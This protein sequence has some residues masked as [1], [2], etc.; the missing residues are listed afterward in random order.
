[1]PYTCGHCFPTKTFLILNAGVV[2]LAETNTSSLV[3]GTS[4]WGRCSGYAVHA[5]TAVSFNGALTMV[6]NGSAGVSPGTSVTGSYSIGSGGPD[7]NNAAATDCASDKNTAYQYLH[8]LLCPSS[9]VLPSS[10]LGG[11]TL[12]PGVWC[13]NSISI[14]AST[15][16]L[17]GTGDPNAEWIFQT[18]TTLITATATLF[19]LQQG[20]QA[21]NVY[22]AIGSS[23]TLGDHSSFVGQIIAHVSISIAPGTTVLGRL[24]ADAAITFAGNNNITLP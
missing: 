14:S 19:L 17:N 24:L 8:G 18:A 10:E 16:T 7:L 12:L 6:H 23:A 22:W 3:N 5:G 1:M 20:A 2:Q 15:L 13:A 11:Q 4:V 9:N 21:K